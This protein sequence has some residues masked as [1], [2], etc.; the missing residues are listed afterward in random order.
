MKTKSLLTGLIFIMGINPV[1]SQEIL[2]SR[3]GFVSA[4]I[5][6]LKETAN[7]G[8]VFGAPSLGYG[9]QITREHA[10]WTSMYE[11]DLGLSTPMT[12]DILGV[13]FHL[14]PVDYFLGLNLP[15][16]AL[17]LKLGPSF[18][19]EYNAQYY[20]D[21]QS[22]YD[23]W[24]TEISIGLTAMATIN[25]GNLV[26]DFKVRNSVTGLTCRNEIENDPY[27]LDLNFFEVLKDVHQNGRAFSPGNYNSTNLEVRIKRN[28]S[29]RV[30][31]AFCADY[32]VY[33]TN[34]GISLLN[35]TV[36]LYI[37]PKY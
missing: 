36:R 34:P 23:F 6:Q 37:N 33:R 22:G 14:K 25:T 16:G 13:N 15:L 3:S 5:L 27:F 18:R 35:Q 29:S 4:G 31:L 12:R 32:A 28:E 11:F 8:V 19:L 30:S 2:A 1:F 20:P 17:E 7:C 9:R 26:V 24:L 10:T 21:L